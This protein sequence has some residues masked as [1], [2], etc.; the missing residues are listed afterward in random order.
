M[1]HFTTASEIG[2]F[3]FTLPSASSPNTVA[4][5]IFLSELGHVTFQLK[6]LQVLSTALKIK[7]KLPI[8]AY[9]DIHDLVYVFSCPSFTYFYLPAPLASVGFS[10]KPSLFPTQV[11]GTVTSIR[12]VLVLGFHKSGFFS[13]L[14]LSHSLLVCHVAPDHPVPL[15]F[16]ILSYFLHSFCYWLWLFIYSYLCLSS[17]PL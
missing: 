7:F 10:R 4:N 8:P 13:F 2:F 5:V 14:G 16:M 15:E 3:A 1:R 9:Q 11:S 6:F 12:N 17:L